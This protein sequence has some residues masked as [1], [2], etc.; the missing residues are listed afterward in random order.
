[1]STLSGSIT[2]EL[3]NI[4]NDPAKLVD[5][6]AGSL[7]G[8]STYFMQLLLV[9]TCLGQGL[10][11][12]RVI[13]LIIAGIRGRVGPNLTEKER[14]SVFFGLKP[15]AVPGG[16]QFS[17]VTSNMILYFMV[18]FGTYRNYDGVV[19]NRSA[20]YCCFYS[21]QCPSPRHKL[22]DDSQLL[23][24]DQRLSAPIGLHLPQHS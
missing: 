6:L 21:L 24:I 17:E 1:M 16:F 23:S 9:R 3:N 8:Q 15:L 20:H 4:A 22:V 18:L 14:N 13:P 11:L 12:C 7:P 2:S 10:E 5:L 19:Q